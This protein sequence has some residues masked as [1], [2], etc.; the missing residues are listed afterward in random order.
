MAV[1]R[2]DLQ[3]GHQ[4]Q[5]QH[6]VVVVRLSHDNGAARLRESD[7]VGMRDPKGAAVRHANRKW[8]KRLL[9]QHGFE[10]LG[11]HIAI[12]SA[13]NALQTPS[14]HDLVALALLAAQ[15]AVG[16]GVADDFLLH[17]IRISILRPKRM[18]MFAR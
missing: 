4:Q 10:L 14:N 13:Q 3:L 16:L 18:A 2:R 6:T 1:C 11:S 5:I 9:V 8:P 12:I 7:E 17:G 15:K